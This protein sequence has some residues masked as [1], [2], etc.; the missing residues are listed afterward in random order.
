[1]SFQD[2]LNYIGI[3]SKIT[4]WGI[5]LFLMSVGIEV[6]PKFKFSPWSA[7][8]GWLGSKLNSKLDHKISTQVGNLAERMDK[9]DDEIH[10]KIDMIDRKVDILSANFNDHV[11][12]YEL[13]SLQ[14][15]RR[16]I[17]DFCNSCMNGRLHTREEFD[18]VIAECDT[19]ERYISEKKVKNG[20]IEAAIKEIKRLYDKCIQE[21]SFLVEGEDR[22]KNNTANK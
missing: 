19:Y 10:D 9:R 3:P 4:F 18:F 5:L 11:A 21:H 22:H 17:L 1:M 6:I 20:V 15:T 7:L 14:D 16:D 8:F 13:K 2:F 12:E